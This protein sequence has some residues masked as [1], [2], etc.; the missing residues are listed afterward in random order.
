MT[1]RVTVGTKVSADFAG[2][3]AYF[4]SRQTLTTS[5]YVRE[6]T[7]ASAVATF[8]QAY[9]LY[10]QKTKLIATMRQARTSGSWEDLVEDSDFPNTREG[11]IAA[12]EDLEAEADAAIEDLLEMK[13]YVDALNVEQ[14]RETATAM[15]VIQS[16]A[17]T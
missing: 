12:I 7:K 1:E 13:K 2:A 9:R 5:A 3:V 11:W 14:D 16:V 4:A 6:A 10:N 15:T 8:K 17:S